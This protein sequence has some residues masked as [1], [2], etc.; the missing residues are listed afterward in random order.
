MSKKINLDSSSF[1]VT[2]DWRGKT[3]TK[4]RNLIK[5]ADS[6]IIEEVKWKTASNPNG[7]LVWYKEGMILTGEVYKKHLR[8]SFAKGPDLKKNDPKGLINSYRAIILKEDDMLDEE[9]FKRL[10]KE[11]VRL[12]IE[13]K[14]K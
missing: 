5:K 4:I 9:S 2:P 10:I 8:F 3:I 1:K 6:E 12:N 13:S 11:A 14:K 7:V